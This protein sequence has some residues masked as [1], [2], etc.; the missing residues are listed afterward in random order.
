MAR[1]SFGSRAGDTTDY[2]RGDSG[3]RPG[4]QHGL[5]L[6]A[7]IALPLLRP[8]IGPYAEGG[9]QDLPLLFKTRCLDNGTTRMPIAQI[10]DI[11]MV[12]DPQ[13]RAIV[14]RAASRGIVKGIQGE[15]GFKY[16]FNNAWNSKDN[17]GSRFSYICQDSMQNKDRHANGFT[18][19]QKHLKGVGERGP[20]KPTYD[21]KGSISV[22]FSFSKRHVEVYYRHCP[23][24]KTV[25][26]RKSS[27]WV[28][29]QSRKASAEDEP[30][31]DKLTEGDISSIPGSPPQ[32]SNSGNPRKR[33][34]EE[35]TAKRSFAQPPSL[36]ELLSRSQDANNTPPEL[37]Q[38]SAEYF[39]KPPTLAYDLPTWRKPVQSTFPPPSNPSMLGSTFPQNPYQLDAATQPVQHPGFQ[40]PSSSIASAPIVVTQRESLGPS[41]DN[42]SPGELANQPQ[43]L[44]QTLKAIPNIRPSPSPRLR[45]GQ[46]LALNACKS[47]KHSKIKWRF[48]AMK[49][50]LPVVHAN[51]EENLASAS[52]AH[53]CKKRSRQRTEESSS[54]G[55]SIN[56]LS[57]I[58][59]LSIITD[60]RSM[61]LKRR[62]SRWTACRRTSTRSSRPLLPWR[63]TD[64]FHYLALILTAPARPV[65][66]RRRFYGHIHN[67][68]LFCF[69][70]PSSSPPLQIQLH[71]PTSA[72]LGLIFI[73]TSIQHQ[74]FDSVALQTRSVF[75]TKFTVKRQWYCL[76]S[77]SPL[78]FA[79]PGN[80][81][82][83]SCLT[84][85]ST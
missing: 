83:C 58:P 28:L 53:L 11:V 48:S 34:R 46:P 40:A 77:I 5:S 64:T 12:E 62:Q 30:N 73:S 79:P 55:N 82:G 17:E 14:Q 15:D 68:S 43:G 16:A 33:K 52:T 3:H 22:K 81:K 67:F 24:H 59:M 45:G 6:R 20:R 4:I 60:Y 71:Q 72:T 13:V 29:Q 19:T 50:S 69:F 36:S 38:R 47:C 35:I 26:E 8:T 39:N 7:E 63:Q 44:F 37:I 70:A 84:I 51:N 66:G 56:L 85:V 10:N 23:V 41:Y 9:A 78:R 80:I 2:L 61:F 57:L 42:P 32:L 31:G 76:G 1:V 18:K 54:D 74:F 21:C 27:G 75:R 49:S 25:A 65:R